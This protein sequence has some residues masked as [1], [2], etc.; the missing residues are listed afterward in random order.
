MATTVVS[1]LELN[2]KIYYIEFIL[3]VEYKSIYR[4]LSYLNQLSGNS[5]D[6]STEREG[7]GAAA[8]PRLS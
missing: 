6:S 2:T 8:A 1:S 7:S 3:R 4:Y 5:M